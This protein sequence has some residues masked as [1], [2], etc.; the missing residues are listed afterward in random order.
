[1]DLEGT[2]WKFADWI[3]LEENRDQWQALVETVMKFWFHMIVGIC[4]AVRQLLAYQCLF[5]AEQ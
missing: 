3:H 2:A 4:W 1:M 5:M